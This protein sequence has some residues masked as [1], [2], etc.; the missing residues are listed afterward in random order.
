VLVLEV[1]LNYS[2]VPE[3]SKGCYKKQWKY[4]MFLFYFSRL[5]GNF[6]GL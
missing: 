3:N 4:K 6:K 5:S 2:N 1:V